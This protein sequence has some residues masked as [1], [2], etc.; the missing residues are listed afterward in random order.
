MGKKNETAMREY[1]FRMRLN[2]FL[3]PNDIR[4]IFRGGISAEDSRE[5][6]VSRL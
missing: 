5:I 6:T 4:F 2:F 3:H 1:A